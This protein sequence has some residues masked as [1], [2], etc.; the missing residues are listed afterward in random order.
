[1]AFSW[2]ETIISGKIVKAS[3]A[4]EIQ[5]N[6]DSIYVNAANYSYNSTD[7]GSNNTGYEGTH[8]NDFHGT[9]YDGDDGSR[10]YTYLNSYDTGNN[11]EDYSDD[12]YGNNADANSTKDWDYYS[13]ECN[14]NYLTN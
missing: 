7:D 1:M 9:Y 6:I 8:D 12:N 10:F 14:N 3:Y 13:Y 2:S 4:V 11:S 5:D